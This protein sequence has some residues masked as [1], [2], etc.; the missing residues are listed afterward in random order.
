VHLVPDPESSA[1]QYLCERYAEIQTDPASE[2][3]PAFGAGCSSPLFN[4]DREL[5]LLRLKEGTE[6]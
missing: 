6:P 4:R 3:S 2:I 5:V 1:G